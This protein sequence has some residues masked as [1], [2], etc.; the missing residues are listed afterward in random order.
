MGIRV[1]HAPIFADAHRCASDAHE[2][3]EPRRIVKKITLVLP[4]YCD[5]GL[6]F[7]IPEDG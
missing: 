3:H 6:L 4:K 5:S 1:G 2:P 7:F